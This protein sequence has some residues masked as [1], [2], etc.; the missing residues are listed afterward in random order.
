MPVSSGKAKVTL[1]TDEQIVIERE[2][3]APKHLVYKAL[4]TPELVK[5]WFHANRGVVTSVEI[6][7]RIGGKWRYVTEADSIGEFG[8]HG[9]YREL[10]P[11]ERIV[12]TE[13]FEGVPEGVSEEDATT[14]NTATLTETDRRTTLTVLIQ[15]PNKIARDAIIDSGM[16]AGMQDAYDLLE[17]VASSLR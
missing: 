11:N 1:P 7:L 3:D 4:T 15:A 17:E 9:E 16:E 14:V 6:D 13:F 5:R 10:V 8:F 2:F 12:W